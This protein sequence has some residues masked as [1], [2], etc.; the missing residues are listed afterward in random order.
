MNAEEIWEAV[1]QRLSQ[2]LGERIYQLWIN[3]M[4]IKYIDGNKVVLTV[5]NKTARD[6]VKEQY[7]IVIEDALAKVMN[8]PS[9]EIDVVVEEPHIVEEIK[10]EPPVK[11]PAP[12]VQYE[13]DGLNANRTFENFVAGPSNRLAYSASKKVAEKPGLTY[14]P[15]FIY[16]K[17]GLGK[18]HLLHAIGNAVKKMYPHIKVKYMQAKQF[19]EDYV[20]HIKS[21]KQS[22]FREK[23]R[24]IDVLLVDDIQFLTKGESTQEEF[25][26]IFNELYERQKQIVIAADR[27]PKELEKISE[28]LR[29]RF[30]WGLIADISKP[31]LE[32]R[33]LILEQ[34]AK[35][36]GISLP[37]K[38]LDII[39]SEI[40]SNV[41]EL[42]SA[43]NRLVLYME[44][45]N[46][47][48][49]DENV[50]REAL[51][52]LFAG[53]RSKDELS[54]ETIK[55]VIADYF[56]IKVSDLESKKRT[57]NITYARQ[58]AMYLIREL[59]DMTTTEI[60][61]E[62]G[63]RDHSTVLHAYDK[64]KTLIERDSRTKREVTEIMQILGVKKRL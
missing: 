19:T 29:T 45:N 24:E 60:G 63:G 37:K 27:S 13:F 23:Y 36:K 5:P 38:V 25:F 41:R 2:T 43:L 15:L 47:S 16:G 39:A 10:K 56:G 6:K 64:I 9:V 62:F 8:V 4:S 21:D 57:K 20:S 44:M 7:G 51:P 61:Q 3:Q 28:R 32:E 18:T 48:V 50:V 26:H 54:T 33:V 22:E 12:R 30:A 17:V 11:T 1:K 35:E 42:E 53:K 34:K 31:T 40:D 14:N 55:K 46:I 58:L 52:D 59:L 49:P